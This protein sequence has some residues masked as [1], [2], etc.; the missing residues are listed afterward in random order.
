MAAQHSIETMPQRR[1]LPRGWQAYALFLPLPLWWAL[2]LSHFI[3]PVI[4]A[5]LL[6][7]LLLRAESL[8]LP[9][10]FGIWLLFLAW[11]V[12]SATQIDT[13]GRFAGFLLRLS[14]YVAATIVFLYLYNRRE[15]VDVL[16]EC[17]EAIVSYI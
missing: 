1:A 14:I 3:W 12:A 6:L 11:M 15:D 9:R 7:S 10:G 17:L 5:G 13:V 8:R 2:G 16:A 4:A